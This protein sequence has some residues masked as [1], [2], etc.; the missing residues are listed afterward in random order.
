ML[1][2]AIAA[3]DTRHVPSQD[4]CTRPILRSTVGGFRALQWIAVWP[5]PH[6]GLGSAEVRPW[7]TKRVGC[8]ARRARLFARYKSVAD[9]RLPTFEVGC[10]LRGGQRRSALKSGLDEAVANVREGESR[11]DVDDEHGRLFAALPVDHRAVE[12]CYREVD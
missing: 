2:N 10:R 7:A 11:G 9:R 1:A 12:R 5:K 4:G 8:G 6:E 3:T